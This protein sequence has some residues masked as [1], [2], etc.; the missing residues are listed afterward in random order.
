MLAHSPSCSG[1]ELITEKQVITFHDVFEG[2]NESW[3]A[4]YELNETHV[5]ITANR[6]IHYYG[7]HGHRLSVTYKDNLSDF[8]AT[9]LIK[10]SYEI[11]LPYNSGEN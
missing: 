9:K 11:N 1:K 7:E 2:E 6:E 3:K 5:F 8:S 10:L 4:R